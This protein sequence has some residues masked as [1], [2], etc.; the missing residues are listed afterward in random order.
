M[1]E[2]MVNIFEEVLESNTAL[3]NS[4]E[5]ELENLKNENVVLKNAEINQG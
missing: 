4:M 2:E 1:K 3:L 5:E